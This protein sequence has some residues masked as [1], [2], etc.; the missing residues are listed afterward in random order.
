MGTKQRFSFEHASFEIPLRPP[1]LEMQM[2][3]EQ[4]NT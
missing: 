3:S 1:G 2:I 4:L